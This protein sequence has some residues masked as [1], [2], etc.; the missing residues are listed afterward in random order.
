MR[1]SRRW[2]LEGSARVSDAQVSLFGTTTR[3]YEFHVNGVHCA[4]SNIST[5]GESGP[6]SV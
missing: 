3:H 5:F 2:F 1:S 6:P 4:L